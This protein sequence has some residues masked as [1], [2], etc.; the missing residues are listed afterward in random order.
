MPLEVEMK[1]PVRDLAAVRRELT[2]L[3]ATH[4]AT[5]TNI[6]TYLAHPARSFAETDEALRVRQIGP[7]VFVTYKGPKLDATTKTRIEIELELHADSARPAELLEFWRRLGFTPVREVRK[8]RELLHVAWQGSTIH[9]CLDRVAGLGEFLE[10]EISAE[11]E[12]LEQSR[13][14]LDSL[15]ARLHLPTSERRSY[16]ELLLEKDAATADMPQNA[17]DWSE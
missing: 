10:L 13:K 14:A 3:G 1:F 6:D 17:E 5:E 12:Q 4:H 15:A 8:D 9:A 11:P 2:A 7:R 16:L